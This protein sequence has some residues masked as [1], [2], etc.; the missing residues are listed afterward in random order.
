M[1][2]QLY[3]CTWDDIGNYSVAKVLAVDESAVHVRVYKE[4]F[5]ARPTTVDP[6][7]LS[8]GSIYDSG[9][10][11]VGHLP[12]AREEFLR[13]EPE[14]IAQTEVAEDEL[15]GYRMWA[16]EPDAGVFEP[17]KPGLLGRVR[18]WLGRG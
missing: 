3:T 18:G 17:P 16:E 6:G 1:P 9:G 14:L 11:G 7:S 13:W 15:D 2:G 5:P 4:T 8:L 10:F 12:L